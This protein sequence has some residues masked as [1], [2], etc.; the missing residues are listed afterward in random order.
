MNAIWVLRNSPACYFK[1]PKREDGGGSLWDYAASA[2]LFKEADAHVS[3]IYG[4]NLDL[5]RVDSSFMNHHGILYVS[6]KS[7]AKDLEALLS[8]GGA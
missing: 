2:C 4:E 5:N 1:F 8:L 7:L 6:D 3:D